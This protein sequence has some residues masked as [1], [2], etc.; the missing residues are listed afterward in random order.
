MQST[1]EVEELRS[2]KD[3]SRGDAIRKRRLEHGIRS[4]R[5]FAEASGVSRNAVTAAEEGHASEGTYQRLEAW[6]DSFDQETGSDLPSSV[7]ETIEF[8]VEGDFGVK[9]TVRGPIT[10]REDLQAAAAEIVRSIRETKPPV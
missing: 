9:V 7:V 1:R 5:E 2:V 4:V 6:L 10:N 3:I 8:V